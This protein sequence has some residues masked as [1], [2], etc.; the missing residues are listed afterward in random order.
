VIL[1]STIF[2]AR[3]FV[4]EL[5]DGSLPGVN[6]NTHFENDKPYTSAI[7]KTNTKAHVGNGSANSGAA[8][9]QEKLQKIANTIRQSREANA[10][11]IELS[12]EKQQELKL[13][14][15]EFNANAESDL[16]FDYVGRVRA[17][18]D[19]I[20]L[21]E[22]NH[23]V[24]AE[25]ATKLEEITLSYPNL[26]GF[27]DEGEV[28][29]SKATCSDDI[30]ATKLS[31]SFFGLPAWDHHISITTNANKI[32]AIT[33]N[34]YAPELS[35]PKQYVPDQAK[36]RSSI[37]HYFSKTTLDVVIVDWGQLGISRVG[38]RDVY[39][40]KLPHVLVKNKPFDIF[41][42]AETSKVISVIPLICAGSDECRKLSI[43]I[44]LSWQ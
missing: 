2:G 10:G 20:A 43:L 4:D 11:Q 3:L 40:Y 7:K 28:A 6:L 32:F 19:A 13:F 37:A 14:K 39:S 41:I 33:G 17:I 27:G 16:K 35:A 30:C 44:G 36:I 42:S 24:P 34:F 26:F 12:T 1:V 29:K 21:S 18:Y 22:V 23:H 8:L 25:L 5:A 9:S 38:N 15:Q 31:K